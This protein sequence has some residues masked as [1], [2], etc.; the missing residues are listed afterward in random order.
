[1]ARKKAAKKARAARKKPARRAAV[2]KMAR[3]PAARK[4]AAKPME[5]PG[6]GPSQPSAPWT[7]SGQSWMPG[8]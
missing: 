5:T 3:K 1:M 7:P 8:Q 2:R 6:Q 4:K